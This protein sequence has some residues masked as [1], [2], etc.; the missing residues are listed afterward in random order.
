MNDSV[1]VVR[2]QIIKKNGADVR[3]W[4]NATR[5]IVSNVQITGQSTSSDFESRAAQLRDTRTFRA[6]YDANIQSGDRVIW[7]GVTY[8]VDGEVFRTKSPTG[9]LS[10]TRCNLIRW[11]G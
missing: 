10:S 5:H 4:K 1:T 6:G 8:E 3:D 11:E 9:R 7:E 2:A